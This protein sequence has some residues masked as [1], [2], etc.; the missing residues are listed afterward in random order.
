M[1]ARLVDLRESEL[2][3]L[4]LNRAQDSTCGFTCTYW[5]VAVSIGTTAMFRIS[6]NR[7]S[8]SKPIIPRVEPL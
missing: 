3:I 4:G 2:E 7:F 1:A 6:M 5:V 8:L